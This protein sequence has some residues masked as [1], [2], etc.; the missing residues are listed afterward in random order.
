MSGLSPHAHDD[1]ELQR[2]PIR[3]AQQAVASGHGKSGRLEQLARFVRLV[4]GIFQP[5]K[6][7]IRL[8]NRSRDVR[9]EKSIENLPRV[10]VA[11]NT[12][13]QRLPNAGIDEDVRV[14]PGRDY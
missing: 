12:E 2:M 14:G 6:H 1:V 11:V 4:L 10:A 5:I 13:R 8:E 9:P 3:V 7:Q